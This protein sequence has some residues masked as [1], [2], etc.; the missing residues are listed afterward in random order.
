MVAETVVNK[1]RTDLSVGDRAHAVE[2]TGELGKTSIS[3]AVV[4]KIAGIAAGQVPGVHSLVTTGLV[5]SL[6]G[7]A[8]RLAR[9]DQRGQGVA[10]E[11]GQ[12]EAAI[13][14]AIQVDF[15]VDIRQVCDAVRRGVVS[16]I[17]SMTGLRVTEVNV[18]VADLHFPEDEGPAPSR[19]VE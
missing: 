10:V 11:V 14:L 8:Q 18:L 5:G 16:R 1:P 9:A 13:D 2:S 6:A 3:D 19:R 17:E 4:A 12:K 7:F 15:G